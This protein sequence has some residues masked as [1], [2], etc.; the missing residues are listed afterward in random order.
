MRLTLALTVQ[1]AVP[2]VEF[3]LDED[4]QEVLKGVEEQEKA[5]EY[6]VHDDWRVCYKPLKKTKTD[7]YGPAGTHARH[8]IV[9]CWP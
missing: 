4:L 5:E 3:D 6:Q 8:A 2:P 9:L 1:E 7:K